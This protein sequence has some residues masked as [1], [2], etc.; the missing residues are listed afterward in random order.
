MQNYR[1]LRVWA[2]AHE[3][4]TVTR[5]ATHKF[6]RYGFGTLHNQMVRA[7]ESIL[8]NIVEGCGANT[9]REFARFLE[10]SS[11][12][13]LELECQLELAR[14]YGI[15]QRKAWAALNARVISVRRMSWGLRRKVLAAGAAKTE[16]R[17]T[18]NPK[19]KTRR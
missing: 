2:E 19:P 17:Q 10:I 18:D 11:K 16:K 14:D 7:A 15:I 6:P 4:A 9:P 5:S 3:L 8:F 12:S 1:K 13:T